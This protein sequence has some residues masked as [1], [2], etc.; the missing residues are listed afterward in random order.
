MHFFS[1]FIAVAAAAA[2]FFHGNLSYA[3][4]YLL[5]EYSVTS[6]GR[7]FAGAGVTG[8]DLSAVASNPAGLQLFDETAGA[9]L[10][11]T[12][13]T[14]NGKFNG[15]V[16]T[17]L[18]QK[19]GSTRVEIQKAVPNFF[20]AYSVTDKIKAGFGV[21]VP[22][23]LGTE[24]PESSIMNMSAIKSDLQVIELAP[25]VSFNIWR[26]LSVGITANVQRASARL[27]QESIVPTGNQQQP[28]TTSNTELSGDDW[29]FGGTLGIMYD[30]EEG[31]R[32]GISYRSQ[33]KHKVKGTLQITG[34]PEMDASAKLSL[35]NMVTL[36]AYHKF[37][38]PIG[39]SATLRYIQWSI[40]DELRIESDLNQ[41]RIHE[42]W[43]DT[44]SAHIGA[45]WFLHEAITLRLGIAYDMT[46]IKNAEYRTARIPDSDRILASAGIS[47]R[48]YKNWTIDIGYTHMFLNNADINHTYLGV[49][50]NGKYKYDTLSYLIGVQA[51]CK[52]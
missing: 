6:M 30:F 9:Q 32:L 51:Q 28:Y 26:G 37:N 17:P 14:L 38:A 1:L 50:V 16:T 35:P 11:A 39:L 24:Y 25:S 18:G 3:S 43:R 49:N 27:T 36:S 21:Y 12:V 8:D 46:P 48:P 47:A 22:F 20:A 31:T 19:S 52:F 40:F 29:A 23:G 4:G 15:E 33:V 34:K 42:D 7:A 10:G 13:I 44:V 5:N 45:D 2:V 41:P